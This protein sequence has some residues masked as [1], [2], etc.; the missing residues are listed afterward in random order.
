[1]TP[2]L[3]IS[4]ETTLGL[5]VRILLCHASMSVR[6]LNGNVFGVIVFVGTVQAC[7]GSVDSGPSSTDPGNSGTTTDPTASNTSSTLLSDCNP[8]FPLSQASDSNPC[9]FLASGSCYPTQDAACGCICPRDKGPVL[10]VA[11][12]DS[13]SIAL[14]QVSC[15]PSS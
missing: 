6:G 11:G 10:C 8:G 15:I 2:R 14:A 5:A 9:Y 4:H 12:T 1:V 7:G 13:W 3:N